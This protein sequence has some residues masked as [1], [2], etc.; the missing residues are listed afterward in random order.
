MSLNQ[1]FGRRTYTLHRPNKRLKLIALLDIF[2]KKTDD[3]HSLT[4]A[5]LCEELGKVGID[6][7]RKSV[8]RDIEALISY[9]FDINKAQNSKHGFYMATREFEFPEV[10]LLVDAVSS[11]PFITEKKTNDLIK[12]LKTL[13]SDYQAEQ[14]SNQIKIKNRIKYKN[15]E[16][17][18]NIDS[19]HRAIENNKKIKF[20][21]YHRRILNGTASLDNGKEITVSPYALVWSND[22][23]YLIA[24]N[25]KYDS[26]SN[27]R[28]DRIKSVKITK[29]SVRPY[30]E[31][32]DSDTNFDVSEYLKKSINMF[33]GEQNTIQLVCKKEFVEILV[34]KFG[35]N[36]NLY[37]KDENNFLAV[38]NV[39]LSEG[40][41]EWL[42]QHGDKVFVLS[43]ESLKK[44][45]LTKIKNI[46]DT[47][48][49]NN[50]KDMIQC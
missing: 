40:L 50:S 7:E 10:R 5:Q 26:V 14:I 4:A 19:I 31:V 37:N 47:Y 32:T 43:P 15:E 39:Y 16:I 2:N 13:L 49:E 29:E 30:E 22:K 35:T 12:K 21:Y 20:I 11:A 41:I 44:S 23:Y 27:F 17:Y 34:D 48:R 25:E 1:K 28:L 46:N 9:G 36:I 45:V 42:I 6:A 33:Y 38:I 3:D 24:N 8:Y 18:Y